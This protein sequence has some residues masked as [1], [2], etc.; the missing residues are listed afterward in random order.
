MSGSGF[1]FVE[2][3]ENRAY[4]SPRLLAEIEANEHINLI[5][6]GAQQ[7]V[8]RVAKRLIK[9]ARVANFGS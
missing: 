3:G 9:P 1:A 7:I 5:E 2:F 6:I 4:S 8:P